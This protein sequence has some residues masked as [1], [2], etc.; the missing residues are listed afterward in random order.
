MAVANG[1]FFVVR[2]SALAA[3][4]GYQSVKQSVIDDVFLARE[5]VKSGSSGTVING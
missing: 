5:L 2:R 4:G 1:H 3:I